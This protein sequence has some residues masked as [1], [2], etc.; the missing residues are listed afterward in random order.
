MELKNI[1][2]KLI[3]FFEIKD[4]SELGSALFNKMMFN[5][6]PEK[7]FDEYMEIVKNLETDW[8]QKIFQYYK[9][10]RDDLKQDYTPKCLSNL[11]ARLSYYE[12]AKTVLDVCCGSGSL[13]IELH[14]QNPNLEFYGIELDENVIPFLLFNLSLHNI[15]ATIYVGDV[16]EGVYYQSYRL[17]SG[18]KYSHIIKETVL[19][20]LGSYPLEDVIFQRHYDIVVSNPPYH[21][22]L[23]GIKRVGDKPVRKSSEYFFLLYY[24]HCI[25]RVH[26]RCSVILPA[27][28]LTS[29][30]KEDLFIR[31][32]LIEK[33]LLNSVI[34]NPPNMFESTA[35][36]TCIL[37]IRADNCINMNTM[38]VDSTENKDIWIREQRGQ[39]GGKAHTNRVY[40]KSFNTYNEDNI[41]KILEAVNYRHE[42]NIKNKHKYDF[43]IAPSKEAIE[44]KNYF[45]SAGQYFETVPEYYDI[46]QE[47]Y[48]NN[49][50]TFISNGE[51]FLNDFKKFKDVIIPQ[52]IEAINKETENLIKLKSNLISMLLSGELE[53]IENIEIDRLEDNTEEALPEEKDVDCCLCEIEKYY[54]DTVNFYKT[55]GQTLKELNVV[56]YDDFVKQNGDAVIVQ[57]DNDWFQKGDDKC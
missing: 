49:I 46:T 29:S 21:L 35:V 8:I 1:C 28:F 39:F 4:I 55:L 42:L 44:D 36:S 48:N 56:S 5:S 57:K 24:L 16:I 25:N 33:N 3:E 22:K 20:C 30:N 43:S 45:F 32:F 37:D 9:S 13:M 40:K 18:N 7:F 34:I 11:L 53:G 26:G 10:N 52:Q 6:N 51:N 47:E 54:K 12:D 50:E 31:K 19:K 17:I 27:G 14:K 38:L 2:D 23:S 41:E 15:N